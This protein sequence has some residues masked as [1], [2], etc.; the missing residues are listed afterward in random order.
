M[1][2]SFVL[3]PLILA[4]VVSSSAYALETSTPVKVSPLLKTR[5]SWDGKPIAY[6]KGTAE[7]SGF[8]FEIAPGAETG[9]HLHPTASFAYLLQ[10]ELE[11]H[12]KNG[13]SKRF[14]AGDAFAEVINTLH[15]GHNIGKVPVKIVV[16][17]AGAADG[18][19][20]IKEAATAPVE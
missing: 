20:T 18:T 8:L 4:L 6:A 19:L 3:L 13:Q 17:Y 9:W 2:P 5:T 11:V 12:L 7:V 16:F 10:G 14:S 1:K 15:D